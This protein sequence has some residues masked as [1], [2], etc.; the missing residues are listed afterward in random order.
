MGYAH[1]TEPCLHPA[2]S[3]TDLPVGTPIG[4]VVEDEASI[5]AFKDYSPP[6]ADAAPAA[7]SP[8]ATA[9]AAPAAAAV[10]PVATA[11]PALPPSSV[12]VGAQAPASPYAKMLAAQ[13][14][15]S[16]AGIA[17]TGPGGRIIA[18]DVLEAA[19]AP[20]AQASATAATAAPS[21]PAGAAYVDLPNTQ[22]RK[23]TAKRM[24][25][26]KNTAPHYYLTMEVEM[27]ALIALRTSINAAQDVK[28]SV[29]DYVI[30]ACAKALMEVPACNSQVPSSICFCCASPRL[31]S[32]PIRRRVR[33]LSL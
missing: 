9:A 25:E 3:T 18:A 15:L 4:I 5:A 17:G 16:L 8:P 6:A 10:A 14:S 23:V 19:A 30:K 7:A 2:R 13:H 22:I 20:A 12:A 1:R 32:R 33:L 28:T 24:V 21:A 11:A 26:N 29:N 27:D 31:P